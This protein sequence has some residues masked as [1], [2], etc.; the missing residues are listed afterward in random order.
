MEIR[1]IAIIAHV[2]HGK[3]T[4]VDC[5]L[6][7]SGS[8]RPNQKV[9]TQALDSNDLERERGITILAKNTS[10]VWDNKRI[11]IV[12][13]PGHADFGGEVERIMSMVDGAL[14][15]VDASEGPMP[16]T[17]FVLRK[18][19]SLGLRPIVVIN[20][21]DK[22][23]QRA[24][25]VHEE[26]FDLF[27]ALGASNEQLDFPV[28]FG[29]AKDGWFS[30]EMCGKKLGI[31]PLLDLIVSHVSAPKVDE[32]G[33]FKMLVTTLEYDPFVGRLLTGK[34]L[35]G[36]IQPNTT[37][38]AISSHGKEIGASRISKLVA[39]RELD[40]VPIETGRAGDIIALSGIANATVSDT[41]CALDVYDPIPTEPIDPPTIAVTFCANDS[42]F[43]GQEGQIVT[44]R[45]IWKRLEREGEGNVGIRVQK[46]SDDEFEVSG[47]GELQLAILIETMRR[48][49]Y[50]LSIGRPR[51]LFIEEGSVRM[52]PVED[53]VIDVDEEYVG[54]VVKKLGS[55]RASLMHIE[56]SDGGM[57]RVVFRGPSRGLIGYLSEFLT[58]TRGTGIMNRSYHGYL[59]YAGDIEQ[60]RNGALVS[61]VTGPAVAYALWNLEARGPL[62]INPNELVYPGM[63]IGE[64]NR[65]GDLDVNPRKSKQLTNFRAASKDEHINLTPV[66][67]MTLDKA[68]V[69]IDDDELVEVTPKTIRMR[70]R[71]CDPIK[72]KRSAKRL[73]EK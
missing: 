48:E 11:N 72:R 58:D 15:L 30:R 63:I 68:L 31:A 66:E 21:V 9:P 69:Y 17:K 12:D 41:I 28:L 42:P 18:A 1:N 25:E 56:P 10:V 53:I 51:V 71:E 20:K 27:A 70:K 13:T 65:S 3:T 49:G 32:V 57:Q 46:K 60:K 55:R 8:F 37:V 59:P 43:A 52:E 4:L 29:S 50:E 38:H 2:D 73:A 44:A 19:L 35:S 67:S 33:P 61:T 6:R 14:V 47:R 16:Q 34:I 54:V 36:H 64:H 23:D 22:K 62:F 7:Q 45:K 24:E 40:R 39:F 5:L 26:T